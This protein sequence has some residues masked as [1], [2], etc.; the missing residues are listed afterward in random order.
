[1]YSICLLFVSLAPA[2]SQQRDIND[3]GA[4]L[5]CSDRRSKEP[6]GYT[7]IGG[8]LV[9]LGTY[10][11]WGTM[12][13]RGLDMLSCSVGLVRF[14]SVFVPQSR[15]CKGAATNVVRWVLFAGVPNDLKNERRDQM[16]PL[17]APQVYRTY[18]VY[19]TAQVV[20]WGISADGKR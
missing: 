10:N 19:Y 12:A 7:Y 2:S 11:I 1:M 14:G 6:T 18:L 17:R 20:L 3:D 5:V 13:I 16:T 4:S 8:R 15:I 9:L